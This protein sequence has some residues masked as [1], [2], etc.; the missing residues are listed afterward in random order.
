[1]HLRPLIY[2]L[3][4]ATALTACNLAPELK[5]PAVEV[6][7]AFKEVSAE[8]TSPV[9]DGSWALA[10]PAMA[11]QFAKG[12]WWRV[13]EDATLDELIAA[14][15]A[16]S[17]TLEAA[18]ERLAQA[19]QTTRVAESRLYPDVNLNAG[20]TR[21]Q[22]SPAN[23]FIPPGTTL[24][25]YTLYNANAS[26]SYGLDIFGRARN[27]AFAA[28]MREEQQELLYRAARITLEADVA[29][30]YYT[31][32]AL[33]SEEKVLGDTL[34]LRKETF[35]LTRKRYEIGDVSDL[36]VARAEGEFA[37][38][39]AEL[40]AVEQQRAVTEHQLAILTGKPPASFT[41][42]TTDIIAAP[43][44]I[45]AGLPS[46]LLERR[47]DVA[48]AE[49]EMAARN[50][51]IGLA[52]A[53]F[54]PSVDLFARF[55]FQASEAGDLFKWS[56]RTWLL[57][58]LSG[59]EMT[60]PLF[61]GGRNVA[62]LALS[63]ASWREG[64]ANYRSQVLVAFQE[65][66]DALSGIRT[67]KG[68]TTA[69]DEAAA[70]AARA[71]KIAKLQYENGFIGYLDSIDAQRSLLAAQRGQ[72]QSRGAQY[73]A[74]ITLVRALGGG[75]DMPTTPLPENPA[76]A[77]EAPRPQPTP[78]DQKAKKPADPVAPSAQAPALAPKPDATIPL[79]KDKPIAWQKLSDTPLPKAK[80]EPAPLPFGKRRPN[81]PVPG[82]E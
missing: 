1:M 27:N 7:A 53:A 25:P 77:K 74:T 71:Y 58:P 62:N 33:R 34:G 59:T 44:S 61:A 2:S 35:D 39:K 8:D 52:R 70:A 68:Q 78:M 73:V 24:K 15:H 42:A 72:V 69:Q 48:Q 51:E 28:L 65:T 16:Q 37:T 50:A 66:E 5:K 47:P 26:I 17:P 10:N 14:A 20:V 22:D 30:A 36:D 13:F 55:G 79:A 9:T 64:V 4:A 40:F 3:L 43:P 18:R 82:I 56:S 49:R 23:P 63:K 32:R 38:T 67:A 75:W 57:G 19:R 80:A 6:P 45:P 76:E 54:F 12:E 60:L 21:Q 31:L 29:Q 41:V 11:E 46:T 81:R